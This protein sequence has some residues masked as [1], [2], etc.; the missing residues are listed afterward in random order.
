MILY[1]VQ[2]FAFPFFSNSH[3]VPSF[4]PPLPRRQPDYP[5]IALT[6]YVPVYRMHAYYSLFPSGRCYTVVLSYLPILSST[7]MVPHPRSTSI[8]T[9]FIS[10]SRC[11]LSIPTII[12]VYTVLCPFYRSVDHYVYYHYPHIDSIDLS[13]IRSFLLD[14]IID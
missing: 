9:L 11:I 2:I 8:G 6:E 4:F 12:F 13:T 14:P 1:A 7:V 10:R 5:M 3:R